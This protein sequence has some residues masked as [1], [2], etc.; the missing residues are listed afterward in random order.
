MS[1]GLAIATSTEF[2]RFIKI[3]EK[4]RKREVSKLKR[5]KHQASKDQKVKVSKAYILEME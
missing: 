1:G 5:W 3:G 4:E 2:H